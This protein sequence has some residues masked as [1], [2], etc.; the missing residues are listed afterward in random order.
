MRI[1][2]AT[3]QIQQILNAAAAFYVNNSRWPAGSNTKLNSAHELISGGYLPAPTTSSVQN[4]WG[5]SI[6]VGWANSH[7]THLIILSIMSHRLPVFRGQFIPRVF[8]PMHHC[9]RAIAIRVCDGR[10]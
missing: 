4:P 5:R 8:L 2:K 9:C 3:L 10:R 6:Y 7:T 1:D